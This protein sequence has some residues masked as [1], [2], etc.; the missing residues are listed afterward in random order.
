MTDELLRWNFNM[1]QHHE[2]FVIFG[3]VLCRADDPSVTLP[4]HDI[5]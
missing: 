4:P 3:V 5:L 2:V 1:I